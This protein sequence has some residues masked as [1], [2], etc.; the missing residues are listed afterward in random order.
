[1]HPAAHELFGM[2]DYFVRVFIFES[3]TKRACG[4]G[5]KVRTALYVL[6]DQRMEGLAALVA[7]GRRAYLAMTG[8]QP[9][10]NRLPGE[11]RTTM[12]PFAGV[13]VLLF[14]AD[15]GG[16]GLYLAGQ[17]GL[18]TPIFQRGAD[19][20]QHKPRGFLADADRSRE[21]VRAISF[22]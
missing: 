11:A 15:A 9:E 8:K 13:F 14:S 18:E 19:A 1:M 16:I 20:M 2:I 21:A 6:A 22:L 3:E 5:K 7:Y 17:W 12:Q 4:I 10:Y